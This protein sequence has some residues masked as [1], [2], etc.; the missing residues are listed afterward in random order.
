[1][2]RVPC[3][4]SQPWREAT[5]RPAP[6]GRLQQ[7]RRTPEERG[8]RARKPGP[9]LGEVLTLAD[10]QLTL[11]PVTATSESVDVR[12]DRLAAQLR[13]RNARARAF[14]MSFQQR[15]IW[16]IEQLHPGTAAYHVPLALDFAEPRQADV[17]Q[18]AIDAVVAH[19]PTLRTTFGVDGT[20]FEPVQRV[21]SRI[22]VPLQRSHLSWL[23]EPPPRM[24]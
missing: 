21:H 10:R 16:F 5:P 13:K 1:M 4:P 9:Y 24:R 2:S 17:M 11:S 6:P 22:D 14:P 15:G 18:C 8:S 20:T 19:H 12:R 23:P 7:I 3:T